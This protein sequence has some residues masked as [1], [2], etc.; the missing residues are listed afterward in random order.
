[1]RA[2]AIAATAQQYPLK[3]AALGVAAGVDFIRT[4]KKPSGYTDTGVALI[5]A[6]AGERAS[7]ARTSR[8]AW[9]CASGGSKRP[10]SCTP[11]ER[12]CRRS[13]RVGPLLALLGACAFFA[14]QSDR[15]LTGD[16][17]SLVL[18]QVMV[19]GVIAIGQTLIILTA[20]VDLSCGMV[21]AL[22]GIV[23]TKLAAE[24]GLPVPRG[25]RERHRRDDAVR[26]D[27]RRCWSPRSSCR[28]SSS[29]SAR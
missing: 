29:R 15:F 14:T 16:N 6:R 11:G 24:L 19:V 18:Q 9:S 4:G 5:A 12:S 2:G 1:M 22:G 13:E 23:M 28:R 27:Q 20:G 8:P 17:L 26:A 21:M 7:R 10:R 3:M 25:D